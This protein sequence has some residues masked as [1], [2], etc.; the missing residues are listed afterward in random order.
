MMN[1]EVNINGDYESLHGR[2][3]KSLT[4]FIPQHHDISSSIIDSPQFPHFPYE[5]SNMYMPPPPPP[6]HPPHFQMPPPPPSQLAPLPPQSIYDPYEKIA[7][8]LEK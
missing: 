6:P 7:S 8:L 3:K 2:R 4:A 1:V 5:N